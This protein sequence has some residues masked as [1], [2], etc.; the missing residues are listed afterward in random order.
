M[1]AQVQTAFKINLMMETIDVDYADDSKRSLSERSIFTWR[2]CIFATGRLCVIAVVKIAYGFALCR[3]DFPEDR[4]P[5][6]SDMRSSVQKVQRLTTQLRVV[7]LL[8]KF[9]PQG[10]R[11]TTPRH[12][13]G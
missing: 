6:W 1:K 11:R 9:G 7:Q 2:M 5:A 8:M 4:Y 13:P 12:S 3:D 10:W